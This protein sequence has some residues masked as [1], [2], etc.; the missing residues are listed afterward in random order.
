MLPVFFKIYHIFKIVVWKALGNKEI[1]Y[2]CICCSRAKSQ[3]L[4]FQFYE[5]VVKCS[6]FE[7]LNYMNL[8]LDSLIKE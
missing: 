6:D 5:S 7:K 3:L 4:N 8:Q 2:L 1:K